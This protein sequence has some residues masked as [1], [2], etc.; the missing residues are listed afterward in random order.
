MRVPQSGWMH[1]PHP[2]HP[3]PHD[4]HGPVRNTYKRS[5]RWVR[6]YRYEDELACSGQ[7]DKLAHVLFSTA[8]AEQQRQGSRPQR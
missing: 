1:E 4:H 3:G 6:V 8:A 2:D 7:E 5:H